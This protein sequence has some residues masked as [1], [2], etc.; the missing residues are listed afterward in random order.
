MGAM[1]LV[2]RTADGLYCSSPPS[3][4]CTPSDSA[5][6]RMSQRSSFCAIDRNA[7]LM[8][9]QSRGDGVVAALTRA[10]V[11]GRCSRRVDG[12]PARGPAGRHVPRRTAHD[13]VETVSGLQPGEQREELVR[14]S[15]LEA[16]GVAV[17]VVDAVVELR[18]RRRG[19][20]GLV[21]VLVLRHRDDASGAGLDRVRAWHRGPG[22]S[23]PC[24]R[25]C[26]GG[27]FCSAFRLMFSVVWIL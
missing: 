11:L 6:S 23:R 4:R 14:R 5:V 12:L 15:R 2:P 7:T 20:E 9:R 27:R 22:P 21:V 16:A 25:T 1:S 8:D 18:R 26:R 13:L 17:L 24:C 10:V 19:L 3:A